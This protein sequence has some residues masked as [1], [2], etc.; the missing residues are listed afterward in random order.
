MIPVLVVTSAFVSTA[1][2]KM[3]DSQIA[4]FVKIAPIIAE[5]YLAIDKVNI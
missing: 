2:D 3:L 5:F 1:R 4:E